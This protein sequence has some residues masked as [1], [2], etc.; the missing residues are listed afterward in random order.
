MRGGGGGGGR[1][2]KGNGSNFLIQ[3]NNNIFIRGDMRRNVWN[4][5]N[6]T[7]IF[8]NEQRAK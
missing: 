8:S 3:R 1:S 7:V 4:E 5:C 6:D 2:I